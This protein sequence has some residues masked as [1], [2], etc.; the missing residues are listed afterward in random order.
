MHSYA[1]TYTPTHTRA[2]PHPPTHPHTPAHTHTHTHI[3]IPT[4]PHPHTPTH[5]YTHTQDGEDLMGELV[6]KGY[7][8]VWEEYQFTSRV[9][10]GICMYLNRHWVK[11][12][13]DEGKKDI[14]NIYSVRDGVTG[15]GGSLG[16][17][18]SEN[19]KEGL[20]DRLGWKCML[21]CVY[22]KY[23]LHTTSI[24]QEIKM[25]GICW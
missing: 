10:N 19:W 25:S 8:G 18:P 1:H 5:P 6:L 7:T 20:G 4:H 13:N 11:R 24:V 22:W 3:P 21:T 9:L 14:Y 23:K 16:T 2:Y 12:E 17:R 15:E